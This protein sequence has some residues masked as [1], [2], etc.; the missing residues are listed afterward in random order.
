VRDERRRELPRVQRRLIAFGVGRPGCGRRGA[1]GSF[2][3]SG[4]PALD[5]RVPS[6]RAMQPG[7]LF[8]NYHVIAEK[9][10]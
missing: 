2:E 5:R 4:G 7:S 8:L 1:N 3:G 9:P 10:A 6:L